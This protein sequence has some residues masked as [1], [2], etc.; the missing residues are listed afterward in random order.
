MQGEMAPLSRF[1]TAKRVYGPQ[2]IG[3]FNLFTAISVNGTPNPD[4]LREMQLM[5]FRKL[6]VKRFLRVTVTNIPV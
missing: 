1:I 4:S 3:R 6:R 2:A 5:L